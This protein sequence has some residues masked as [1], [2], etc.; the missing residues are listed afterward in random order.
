MNAEQEPKYLASCT[1][2]SI[3]FF[4]SVHYRYYFQLKQSAGC[5]LLWLLLYS[6]YKKTLIQLAYAKTRE[7]NHTAED[8]AV[9]TSGQV[10]W[11]VV[12]SQL[13]LGSQYSFNCGLNILLNCCLM[14]QT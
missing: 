7:W 8:C 1:F 2:Q 10:N 13:W 5:Y 11:I 6:V 12:N 4:F 14:I 9:F 3:N